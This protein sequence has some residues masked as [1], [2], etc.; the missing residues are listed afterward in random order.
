MLETSTPRDPLARLRA[1]RKRR[2]TPHEREKASFPATDAH[3]RLACARRVAVLERMPVKGGAGQDVWYHSCERTS[4]MRRFFGFLLLVVVLATGAAIGVLG[5]TWLDGQSQGTP[6]AAAPVTAP[7]SPPVAV[8]VAPTA[9]PPPT[10]AP[11]APAASA[12]DTVVEVSEAELQAQLTTMLVGRS[13]GSTPL[14]DATVQSVTVALRDRKINVGGTARAGVL[15]APFTATGTITPD[16]NGRPLVRIDEATV[17]GVALPESAR[18]ALADP[19][20]TQVDGL[21]ADRAMKVREIEIADGKMRL[22]GTTG[23]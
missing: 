15:N 13:L 1:P 12:R 16:G 21:F 9:P 3:L 11:A 18:A 2:R 8:V 6:G 10:S 4:A 19:L 5:R 22:V 23:S 7:T 17:G 20:Q 14:G